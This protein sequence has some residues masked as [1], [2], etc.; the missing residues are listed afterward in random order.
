MEVLPDG[1][2]VATT[3]G[4]WIP[5]QSPFIVSLRLTLEELDALSGERG[6]ARD[7]P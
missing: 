5:D 3:H 1:T 4:H 6:G 2:I 7:G